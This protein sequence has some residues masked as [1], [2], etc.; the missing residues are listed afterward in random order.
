[1]KHSHIFSNFKVFFGILILSIFM[2]MTNACS[3]KSI[4]DPKSDT[5]DS[6]IYKFKVKAT[7]ISTKPLSPALGNQQSRLC[8]G[9]GGIYVFG[10][11]SDKFMYYDMANDKWTGPLSHTDQ[12]DFAGFSGK[13][14]YTPDHMILY[15]N[16][17]KNIYFNNK[18]AS[19][20]LRNKWLP[21]SYIGTDFGSGES[22]Q[23]YFNNKIYTVGG[24]MNG[25]NQTDDVRVYNISTGT[26]SVIAH[27]NQKYSDASAVVHNNKLY[28]IG[29]STV[30]GQT[31]YSGS[32]FDM[33]N[34]T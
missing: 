16:D 22:G 23:V 18:Y 3:K 27:L 2:L 17:Y 1:M 33:V 26:W 6:T 20:S 28:I 14:I 29:E 4:D 9:D 5:V 24:R 12:L 11:E 21:S 32:I 30:S 31:Y 15:L 19:S 10:R 25:E 13:M 34:L 8:Y 7:Q